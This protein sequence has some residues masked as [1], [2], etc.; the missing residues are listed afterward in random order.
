[1]SP[2]RILMLT[3]MK[4]LVLVRYFRCIDLTVDWT[5]SEKDA[6]PCK[7]PGLDMCRL[8]KM[9]IAQLSLWATF[10]CGAPAGAPHHFSIMQN[11]WCKHI[12]CIWSSSSMA[13]CLIHWIIYMYSRI[14][15]WQCIKPF[16]CCMI[17]MPYIRKGRVSFILR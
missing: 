12:P 2:C 8:Q 3:L 10:P 4:Y 9:E 7:V 17:E 5:M 6:Q 11:I 13:P 16:Y 14:Y 15:Y 1:M